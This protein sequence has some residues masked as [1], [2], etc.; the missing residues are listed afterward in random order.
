MDAMERWVAYIEAVA[1]RTSRD[2]SHAYTLIRDRPELIEQARFFIW[3]I[4]RHGYI[5]VFRRAPYTLFDVGDYAY[6][7]MGA[8]V[9]QTILI[10][11]RLSAEITN[12]S[13]RSVL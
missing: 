6:W 8:P 5:T 3:Y 7:T 9:E 12:K 10:N 4:R 11:R 1:W 2:G 13:F